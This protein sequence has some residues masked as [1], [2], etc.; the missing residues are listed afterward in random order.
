MDLKDGVLQSPASHPC[1]QPWETPQYR[2][3]SHSHFRSGGKAISSWTWR[4]FS[5]GSFSKTLQN[6]GKEGPECALKGL[7]LPPLPPRPRVTHPH[8]A[9]VIAIDRQC[10]ALI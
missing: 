6:Q 10:E 4:L 5:P 1:H 7:S 3:R 2:M 8:P 9:P